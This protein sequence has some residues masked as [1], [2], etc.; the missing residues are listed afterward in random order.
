MHDEG[1][2]TKRFGIGPDVHLR[3]RFGGRVGVGG[4]ELLGFAKEAVYS[5]T[6]DFISVDVQ[7]PT[8]GNELA[9]VPDCIQKILSSDHI[10]D[11]E[12]KGIFEGIL[13]VRAGGRVNHA[14]NAIFREDAGHRSLVSQSPLTKWKFGN[15]SKQL[16]LAREETL[17]TLSK[18]TMIYS[19]Y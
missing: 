5:F 19:G 16:T 6:V 15:G 8:D 17:S 9:V 1:R 4:H 3:G 12:G 13:D 14:V 18:Q 10:V 11:G 7:E 2:N